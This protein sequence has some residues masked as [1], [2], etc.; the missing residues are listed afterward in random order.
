MVITKVDPIIISYEKNN[1]KY[2]TNLYF[3]LEE[4][5]KLFQKQGG[6]LDIVNLELCF[7][8]LNTGK[9]FIDSEFWPFTNEDL[10]N[11]PPNYNEAYEYEDQRSKFSSEYLR[12]GES[13]NLQIRQSRRYQNNNVGPVLWE[14]GKYSEPVSV[15]ATCE[16]AGQ[17]KYDY[18]DKKLIF[19]Y[20]SDD[21][22]AF[23]DKYQLFK[24]IEEEENFEPIDYEKSLITKII[25][26][27]IDYKIEDLSQISEFK[28][29]ILINN[30]IEKEFTAP[31][32]FLRPLTY[33][34]K[35][36][37]NINYDYGYA[38]VRPPASTI[39][40]PKW[41]KDAWGNDLE[42]QLDDKV[43]I[44]NEETNISGNFYLMRRDE[45]GNEIFLSSLVLPLPENTDF[46]YYDNTIEQGKEYTYYL[47]QYNVIEDTEAPIEDSL[48]TVAIPDFEDIFL[49]DSDHT[50][51]IRYNPKMSSFKTTIL[52][53][54]IDTI[55]GKYPFFFRNGNV[56]YKE[57]PVG[58][59]IS[60]HADDLMLFDPNLK[61]EYFPEDKSS[62]G[63]TADRSKFTSHSAGEEI[64]LERKYKRAVEEWL[65]NGKPKLLRTPTEGN[66]IVRLMNVSLSPMEQLNR[67]LHSFS[68]TGYE[69]A[70]Y[71]FENLKKYNLVKESKT[72][73]TKNS[74]YISITEK[75]E[76]FTINDLP[77]SLTP[78]EAI[79]IKAEDIKR[80]N[81]TGIKFIS[82]NGAASVICNQIEGKKID[83]VE[84]DEYTY[85]ISSIDSN[86]DLVFWTITNEAKISA[87]ISYTYYEGGKD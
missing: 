48:G 1:I 83:L 28:I 74:G 77:Y 69:M 38:E 87:T 54:K 67:S 24:K 11:R 15:I 49:S 60:Y 68:A 36:R 82:S 2:Q 32:S 3:Q 62:R 66:F 53:Q 59:L 16:P 17:F 70:D 8:N 40:G 39:A 19:I 29:K 81:I 9:V 14:Y 41:K 75:I 12:P 18:I 5:E 64:Y 55:G 71:N 37:V 35:P 30:G 61:E 50:L 46:V 51:R 79:R 7:T 76:N 58:G 80:R 4:D 44:F 20:N 21:P 13:Y 72:A 33:D 10:T 45:E 27:R 23:V 34:L 43:V 56:A 26:A 85:T 57:L 63:H 86:Q 47:K 84:E 25:P 6:S 73:E 52:E 22:T 42:G 65:T 31:A 78:V